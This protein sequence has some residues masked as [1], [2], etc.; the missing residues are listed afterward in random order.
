MK[1]TYVSIIATS[2]QRT[3]ITPENYLHF[4]RIAVG[5]TPTINVKNVRQQRAEV[6]NWEARSFFTMLKPD[7]R[8]SKRHGD[9]LKN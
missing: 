5:K 9:I 1:W 8:D 3:I 4:Q 6:K 7:A 2:V